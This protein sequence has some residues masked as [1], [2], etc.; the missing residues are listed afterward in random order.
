MAPEEIAYDE[1]DSPLLP[2]WPILI[3]G[4]A[5]V[6]LALT[7][8][9]VAPNAGVPVRV[10]LLA[11]GLVAVGAAVAL[12]LPHRAS[13]DSD[14]LSRAAMLLAAA[15][16][17]ALGWSALDPSWDSG[18]FVLGLLALAAVAGAALIGLPE[19]LAASLV[20]LLAAFHLGSILTAV[21]NVPPPNSQP[22]WLANQV[23]VYV[24]RPYLQLSHLNNGYHFYAP[25]PGPVALLWFRVKYADGT[26]RWV[27]VTD[28][29]R[30]RNGLETRRWGS[31]AQSVS[32]AQP[33]PPHVFEDLLKRRQEAGT[34]H[35][36]PIPMG[37]IPLNMQHEQPSNVSILM[38]RSYVRY[39]ARTT[40]HPRDPGQAVT[41]VRIYRARYFYPSPAQMHAGMD[42]YDPTLYMVYYMGEYDANGT[43]TKDTVEVIPL[44]AGADR[45]PEIKQDPYLYWLLP[46]Y[47]VAPGEGPVPPNEVAPPHSPLLNAMRIHAGEPQETSMP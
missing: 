39:V 5:A 26:A 11:A 3:G 34:K 32:D 7:W 37:N 31:L 15:G 35:V 9:Q 29:N 42:P 41:V 23:L 13:D 6:L 12:R 19:A 40:P 8:S 24:Y 22:P 18:T 46:I 20:L 4:L 28:H 21:V 38:L 47:R 43:A 14:R 1:P 44:P 16:A 25:E 45:E 27:R 10:L 30:T 36:P 33:V 2:A 17:C